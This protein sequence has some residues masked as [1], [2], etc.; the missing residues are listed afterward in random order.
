MK[1]KD[2]SVRRFAAFLI[3]LFAF[4]TVPTFAQDAEPVVVDEVIAQVNEGVITLSRV[5]REM[6]NAIEGLVQQGKRTP[7][8]AQ[9]E[10]EAKRPELIA[11]LINEELLLQQAK[12]MGI[13]QEVEQ[14][15]NQ[16][17]VAI[18]KN[19]NFKTLEELYK[20]MREQGEDP[21]EVKAVK[22]KDFT[23]FLVVRY[24]V[25]GKIYNSLSEKE[26]RAYYEA[27][28]DKF[29]KPESVVL[30]EIF[31]SFAGKEEPVVTAQAAEVVKK[32]RVANADFAKLVEQYSDR[33]DSKAKQGKVGA[34]EVANLNEQIAAAIKDVKAGGVAEPIR[35]DEGMIIL[36][37]DERASDSQTPAFDERR[38]REAITLERS[39]VERK[40]YMTNLR[41]EAY[42]KISDSYKDSVSKALNIEETK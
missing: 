13:E 9:R 25:E 30:S 40:K 4:S 42:I 28:K 35:T 21:E 3:A 5:R 26:L 11:S 33:T 6:K 23:K 8:E 7:E 27:N 14:S 18:M 32:A 41:T 19:F 39:P 10:L 31:L 1:V 20:A 2:F 38:V 16:E 36:R 24:G 12:E 34:Y 29:K 17:F 37:V 22:R 15:V